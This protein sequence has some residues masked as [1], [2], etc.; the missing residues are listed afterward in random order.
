M[1][2]FVMVRLGAG[3]MA[4]SV[5]GACAVNPRPRVGV[6]Y[7]VRQPPVERVEAISAAPGVEYVWSRDT[8]A[9]GETTTS[10]SRG[11]GWFR[12]AAT[13]SGC[14]DAGSA[15][16]AVGSTSMVTGANH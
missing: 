10:G 6:A 1:S 11:A 13:V 12:S 8:G 14:L 4:V 15:T 5:I 2:K 7:V 9:G 16:A 3:L